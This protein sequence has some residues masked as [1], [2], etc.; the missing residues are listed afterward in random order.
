MNMEKFPIVTFNQNDGTL[1]LEGRSFPENP[2][3]FYDDIAKKVEKELKTNFLKITIK[4][5]YIN[6]GSAKCILTLFEKLNII[7][8]ISITWISEE[9]DEDIIGLGK[10]LQ[11]SLNIPFV[12]IEKVV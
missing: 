8:N 11:D 5:D 12:F 4:L 6:S 10:I 7:S 3:L 2:K 1:K 9:D